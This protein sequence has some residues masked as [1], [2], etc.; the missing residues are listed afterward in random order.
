MILLSQSS[1]NRFIP[2]AVRVLQCLQKRETWPGLAGR[3]SEGV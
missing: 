2:K 1:L 3:D